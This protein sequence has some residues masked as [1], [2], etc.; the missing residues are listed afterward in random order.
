MP[1]ACNRRIV[2]LSGPDRRLDLMRERARG[3]LAAVLSVT[4][5]LGV[6]WISRAGVDEYGATGPILGVSFTGGDGSYTRAVKDGITLGIVPDFPWTYQDEKTKEYAGLD[7]DMF[8]EITKRL[9]I[10]KVTWE[11]M[12]F[13]SLIAALQAKRID[14]IVDNIHENEG[15]L[16][17][18]DFTSPAYWYG[19]AV[20]V[21]KGNPKKIMKWEDF[22]GKTVGTYRGTFYQPIMEARKDLKELKLF[23]TSDVEFA[24]LAAGRVDAIVDDDIKMLQFIKAHPGINMEMSTV[25]MP[26]ELQLGYA[27]YALRKTD[28][29]LNHALSRAID[30]MRADGTVGKF[31]V[32]TG[33]PARYVVIPNALSQ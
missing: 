33:L 11:I 31:L 25:S 3:I 30:E 7:V 9:G 12:P 10:K 4:V 23:T 28:V 13:D 8:R 18:I 29:D 5:L 16:K 1:P 32:K 20:A 21:Q 15:R 2:K 26:I 14:V 6:V 19:A 17:V 22:A 24:D 27:R